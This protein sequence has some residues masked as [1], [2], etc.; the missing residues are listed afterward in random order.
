MIDNVDLVNMEHVD[1]TTKKYN[2]PSVQNI[3]PSKIYDTIVS[4]SQAYRILVYIRLETTLQCYIFMF[5]L[6]EIFFVG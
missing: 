6:E 2:I 4:I 3:T 5:C 1:P